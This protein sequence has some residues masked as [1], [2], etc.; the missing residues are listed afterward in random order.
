[1]IESFYALIYL[2]AIKIKKLKKMISFSLLEYL[3]FFNS[4]TSE[5]N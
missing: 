5:D 3:P 1:M 2:Y 4:I